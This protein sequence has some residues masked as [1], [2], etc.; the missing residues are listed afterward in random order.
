MLRGVFILLIVLVSCTTKENTTSDEK[1]GL[2]CEVVKSVLESYQ[3]SQNKFNKGSKFYDFITKTGY[4]D[5]RFG[6]FSKL[7][8]IK[9]GTLLEGQTNS[10]SGIYYVYENL[11]NGTSIIL[12]EMIAH[13][14]DNEYQPNG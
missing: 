14:K 1:D 7:S 6:V 2:S 3:S 13:K 9:F 11:D 4:E 8:E 5:F 12:Y 10:S